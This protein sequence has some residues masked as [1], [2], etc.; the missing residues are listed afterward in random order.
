VI[1]AL[2]AR[3]P[4]EKIF[5]QHGTHGTTLST[6]FRLAKQSGIPI[7]EASR[8]RFL[9]LVGDEPNQGVLALVSEATYVELDDVLAIAAQR[10]EHPFLLILD[11]IEDPHN[12]GALIRTADCAGVHGVVIP[13]HHAATVNQTV[14]KTSAGA[15]VHVAIAR[16]TNV[17]NAVD[18]MKEKQ[19]RVLG[20]EMSANTSLYDADLTGPIAVVIGNEGRGIRRLVK[21]KCDALVR[22]PMFG[23]INSLNASV[24]GALLMYEVVRRRKAY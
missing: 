10:N 2:K 15:A 6:I 23:K 21:D 20:A 4:I 7:A 1:E 5:V 9:E 8:Q 16:V 14:V 3:Q 22:I 13:K 17:A 18:E 12:L 11:E 19:L 24:S